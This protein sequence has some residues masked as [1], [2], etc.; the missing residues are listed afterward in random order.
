MELDL[1]AYARDLAPNLESVLRQSELTERQ[2]WGTAVACGIAARNAKFYAAIEAEAQKHLD[3]TAL[4]AAQ[5]AAAMMSISNVFYRFRHLTTNPKYASMPV[6]LRLQGLRIPDSDE[7]DFELWCLA[8][9]A[10]NACA[11][12]VDGHERS[13]REKGLTEETILAAVR[14]ASVI[15]AIATVL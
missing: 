8:V 4:A 11:A 1:P 7:I 15:Q 2:T 3:A 5:T 12:C 10:I 14:V 6:R 9:S 13:L